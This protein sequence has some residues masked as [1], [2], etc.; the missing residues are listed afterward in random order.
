MQPNVRSLDQILSELNTVY[1]PQVNL[2]RQQQSS[3]PDQIASEEKGLQAK[4]TQAFDDILGG[5]RRRGL[6]FAGI[7]LGEQAKYTATEFLPAV[8]RLKQSGREQAT[9]LE[10][11]ILG[12]NERRQ[13]AAVEAQRYDQSRYDTWMQNERAL[14]EQ[15]RQAAAA[16]TFRWPGGSGADSNTAAATAKIQQ[17]SDRG[18]NFTDASGRPISAAQYSQ[19]KGVPF[20]TL[21]QQMA[22]SGDAGA[23]QALDFVG[24]DY[25]YNAGKVAGNQNIASLLNNLLWGVNTVSAPGVSPA[26][27]SNSVKAPVNNN[28][29]KG[30]FGVR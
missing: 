3:I 8:A 17:R 21:L 29:F 9:S 23:K 5:A 27:Q 16:N 28:L 15:R 14:A 2:L 20:R 24:D 6:G 11:A 19:L 22:S 7:P 26:K 13:N 4:Q 12:I 18:F 30:T 25:G 1:D 10:Q